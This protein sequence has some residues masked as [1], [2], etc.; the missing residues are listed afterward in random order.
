MLVASA[1]H[2]NTTRRGKSVQPYRHADPRKA[3]YGLCTPCNPVTLFCDLLTSRS[4]YIEGRLPCTISLAIFVLTA[5]AVFRLHRGQ[6]N[7]QTSHM[8]RCVTFAVPR[9]RVKGLPLEIGEILHIFPSGTESMGD[10]DPKRL[11]RVRGPNLVVID[12]S[13]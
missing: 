11:T 8:A 3:C 4:I 12:Q 7:R 1:Q 2:A 9:I 10:R 6:R 13:W 5:E